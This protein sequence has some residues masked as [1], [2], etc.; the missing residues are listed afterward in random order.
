MA[1]LAKK[2]APRTFLLSSS[3]GRFLDGGI[4]TD[5][6]ARR[7]QSRHG[8][9]LVYGRRFVTDTVRHRGNDRGDYPLVN[10]VNGD[11][12]LDCFSFFVHLDLK[13]ISVGVHS[14][15][16]LVEHGNWTRWKKVR[17]FFLQATAKF[18]DLV[19]REGL[20]AT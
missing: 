6:R 4:S 3:R 5:P 18:I 15:V 19:D 20:T 7:R 10:I 9:R 11:C 8:I 17:Y 1:T 2:R 14:V 16:P 12:T 13:S